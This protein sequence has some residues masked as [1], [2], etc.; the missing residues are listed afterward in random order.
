MEYLTDR[1]V[2]RSVDSISE[3][4][5]ALSRAVDKL[6]L[7]GVN[8][9]HSFGRSLLVLLHLTTH[10]LVALGERVLPTR[11]HPLDGSPSRVR[12]YSLLSLRS[13][14]QRHDEKPKHDEGNDHR[15]GQHRQQE[16][17]THP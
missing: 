6:A 16:R 1:G 17:R 5:L 11:L 13:G 14:V 15:D 2:G 9:I 8:R 4:H 10:L 3:V 7:L 12:R